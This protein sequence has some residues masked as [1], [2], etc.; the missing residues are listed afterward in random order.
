MKRR[1]S[2]LL[3][4]DDIVGREIKRKGEITFLPLRHIINEVCVL[5]GMPHYDRLPS[6]AFYTF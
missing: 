1:T 6:D 4:D 3:R 5:R 2:F